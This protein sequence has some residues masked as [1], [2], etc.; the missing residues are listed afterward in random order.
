MQT[1]TIQVRNVKC[2]GCIANVKKNL[3]ELPGVEEVEVVLPTSG[4]GSL[5]ISVV[6]IRGVA[7][8]RIA[9]IENLAKLG[10]PT[11]DS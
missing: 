4:V 8:S 1:E 6:I 7:L 2:K 9:L 10:Y 3:L 5:P 11:S